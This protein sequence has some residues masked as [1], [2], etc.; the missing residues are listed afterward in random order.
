MKKTN[1][2]NWVKSFLEGVIFVFVLSTFVFAGVTIIQARGDFC[3]QLSGS[4][5][6]AVRYLSFF[7]NVLGMR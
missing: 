3:A 1:L 6:M 5:G 7:R 2:R 4:N